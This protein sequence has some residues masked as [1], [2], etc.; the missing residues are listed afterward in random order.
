MKGQKLEIRIEPEKKQKLKK[1]AR[2]LNTT[3]SKIITQ[4]ID[5]VIEKNT[6]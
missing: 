2:Q 3:I 1:C 6:K 4:K 5:E